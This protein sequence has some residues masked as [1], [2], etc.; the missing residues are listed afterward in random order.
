MQAPMH[1]DAGPDPGV[2]DVDMDTVTGMDKAMVLWTPHAVGD[3]GAQETEQ[4]GEDTDLLNLEVSFTL[5]VF[6][7]LS[8]FFSR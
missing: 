4:A 1:A 6:L 8:I 7:T 5:I 3:E 2:M